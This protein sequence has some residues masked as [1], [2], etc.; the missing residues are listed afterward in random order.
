MKDEKRYSLLNRF[1]LLVNLTV[2]ITV[3]SVIV[4]TI[5]VIDVGLNYLGKSLSQKYAKDIKAYITERTYIENGQVQ[6]GSIETLRDEL[7]DLH[8]SAPYLT[9][10][11]SVHDETIYVRKGQIAN[12]QRSNLAVPSIYQS[13]LVVTNN[14]MN[15]QP[16]NRVEYLLQLKTGAGSG[17]EYGRVTVG[18]GKGIILQVNFII[19]TIMIP[20]SFIVI[21]IMGRIT[22]WLTRPIL[23]PIYLLTDQINELA[24][25]DTE[26]HKISAYL[27]V[28]RHKA[29]EIEEL[30]SATNLLLDKMFKLSEVITQSE[31][32]VSV[33]QLTAA[34]TH[35][36]NTPLGA[37]KSNTGIVRMIAENIDEVDKGSNS[38]PYIEQLINASKLAEEAC[39]RIE[40][41]IRSLKMF[42]RIDQSDFMYADINESIRSVVVLTT[43]LHKNKIEVIEKYGTIPEVACHIGLVNQVFMNIFVNAI[44][45]IENYGHITIET[46]TDNINVYISITDSGSGI[47]TKDLYH[48]FQYG[49]TTKQPGSGSGIGLALSNNIIKKH[50]G[51]ICVDSVEGKGSTFTVILPI[52]HSLNNDVES[53]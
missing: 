29:Y 6:L 26:L 37:I 36:I 27:D 12:E 22:R 15:E 43:N 25:A 1:K 39:D 21:Q 49:F 11:V 16:E 31:K 2:I 51:K 44:Q 18:I 53:N 47:K 35:E 32:M 14:K 9:I 50:S 19:L 48:I 24:S 5:L 13:V 28:N 7:N 4:M 40:K 8:S 10:I 17:Q 52:N 46:T 30:A 3:I 34:I 42:S 38:V 33:G 20:V 41:I 45:A 23:R